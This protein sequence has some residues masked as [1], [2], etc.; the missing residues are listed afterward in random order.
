VV[1]PDGSLFS[2]FEAGGEST[3]GFKVGGEVGSSLMP[4]CPMRL[5]YA[6][7]KGVTSSLIDTTLREL[8]VEILSGMKIKS[9]QVSR[10]SPQAVQKGSD[11]RR[12]KIDERRRTLVR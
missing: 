8:R 2:F 3:A 7:T 12:A 5:Y 11:A 1:A 10:K 6:A 4:W 9:K